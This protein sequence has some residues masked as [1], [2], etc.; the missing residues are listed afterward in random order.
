MTK[1]RVSKQTVKTRGP[2]E[3]HYIVEGGFRMEAKNGETLYRVV[4]GVGKNTKIAGGDRNPADGG[5]FRREIDAAALAAQINAR[6][7]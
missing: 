1:V 3:F 7:A 2:R 6:R 5:G 4:E